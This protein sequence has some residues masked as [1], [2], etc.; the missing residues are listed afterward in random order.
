MAASPA[1]GSRGGPRVGVPAPFRLVTAYLGA[2]LV[3][4][5]LVA[6]ALVRAASD[7]AQGAV[8]APSVLLAVHLL[9][10][11]FLPL[12]VA[13]AA[14]HVLPTLLRISGDARRGWTAFG[15]LCAGPVLAVGVARHQPTVTWVSAALVGIGLLVLLVDIG[16]LVAR[17]PRGRLLLASRF[18]VA[19]SGVHA[20]LAFLVGPLLFDRQ[21]RPWADIPH[22]RLIAIHLHLAVIGWLT[23]LLVTVGR[24]LVPMLSLAP[25]EPVRRLPAEELG[26]AGG[27]WIG[28]VGF[29]LGERWLLVA[30]TVVTLAALA[31]FVAVLVRAARRHR[32]H[33]LEG[34]IVHVVV[35]LVFLVEAAALAVVLLDRPPSIGRL[36]AYAVL[37]LVGW[38]AGITLGHVGK[39][40]SLSAWMW[41][42]PGP[43]PK[44]AALYPR[45]VWVAEAVAFAVG[46]QL[47]A[48]AAMWT[49]PWAARAGAAA[50]V[51]SAV[52]A[53]IAAARTLAVRPAAATNP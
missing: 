16:V 45:R 41:W 27:M 47:V 39:L 9:G 35:G 26:V 3:C 14:L 11:G 36:T 48:A 34:P 25:S 52:L 51:V 24:T 37:L 18:G 46:V 10:L 43:R 17:A 42:P 31:S 30:G 13:G 21:W 29:A 32:L 22:D 12:A 5:L 2:G 19:A 50:L 28:M 40:L 4:W 1:P 53:L 38:A 8:V 7:I 23:L 33:G 20:L 6:V 44:Q 49:V 15:G